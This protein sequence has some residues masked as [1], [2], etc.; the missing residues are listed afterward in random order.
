MAYDMTDFQ[1]DV[2]DASRTKP[3]LVDFWA[4]WCGPCKVLGPTLEKLAAEQSDAWTL[5]K[6]DTEAH[7]DLA[8][9][10]Q[11]RSIPNCKLFVDGRVQDEFVGALPE[12]MLRQWL[13]KAIPSPQRSRLME[14]QSLL[15][16]NQPERARSVL[17][18]IVQ[19]EPE[20]TQAHLMLAQLLLYADPSAAARHLDHIEADDDAFPMAEAMRT[21]LHLFERRANPREL[22]D[23]PMRATFL[24][25]IEKLHQQDFDGALDGFIAVMEGDRSYDDDGARKACIA[26]FRLLGEDDERTRR[27]R[28]AFS[29]AL[30]V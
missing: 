2:L 24:E 25:A 18:S 3:V 5:V 15:G 21:L 16:A 9:Q 30:Y 1:R 10:Y 23:G 8:G 28:R 6:V 11:V 7:P 27:H 26:I 22:G 17:E 20:N 12:H 29:S 14:A 19:A 4:D 13:Q